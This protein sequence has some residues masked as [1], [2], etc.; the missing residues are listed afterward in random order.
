[1]HLA[2]LIFSFLSLCFSLVVDARYVMYLTGYLS[3]SFE[4]Y[5][6]EFTDLITCLFCLCFD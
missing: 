3:P 5:V 1:M 2:N 6:K 4:C